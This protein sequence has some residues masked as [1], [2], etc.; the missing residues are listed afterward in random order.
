VIAHFDDRHGNG[1]SVGNPPRVR[2]FTFVKD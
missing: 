2:I 1:K